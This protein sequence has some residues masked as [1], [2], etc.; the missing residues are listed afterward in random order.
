MA[1]D[2]VY[3]ENLI[4]FLLE[5]LLREQIKFINI[6]LPISE[7]FTRNILGKEFVAGYDKDAIH[8]SFQIIK[9]LGNGLLNSDFL[10][11]FK[12]TFF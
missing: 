3:E 9:V 12:I 6:F 1:H 7:A 11:T 10:C 5:F 2:D 4:N 8:F